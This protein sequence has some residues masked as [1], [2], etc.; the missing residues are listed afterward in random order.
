MSLKK[1]KKMTKH[2]QK[3]Y[4]SLWISSVETIE[5]L[6]CTSEQNTKSRGR[7][8]FDI[9]WNPIFFVIFWYFSH[10]FQIHT[11]ETTRIT[12][13]LSEMNGFTSENGWLN[14]SISPKKCLSSFLLFVKCS[15]GDASHQ[16]DLSEKK[17]LSWISSLFYVLCPL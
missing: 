5:P 6:F 3:Q 10:Y 11:G 12:V 9:H 7:I 13:R 16:W 8:R 14:R 2:N 17:A 15:F 1:V 4:A